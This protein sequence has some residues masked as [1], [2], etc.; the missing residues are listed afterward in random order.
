MALGEQLLIYHTQLG[1]PRLTGA[2]RCPGASPVAQQGFAFQKGLCTGA[3][4][5]YLAAGSHPSG[6]VCREAQVWRGSP[7][8]LPSLAFVNAVLSPTKIALLRSE[9]LVPLSVSLSLRRKGD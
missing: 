3:W 7:G 6:H 8:P 9:F 1:G 4:C 5:A 2:S